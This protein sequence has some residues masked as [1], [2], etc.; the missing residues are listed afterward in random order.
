MPRLPAA[1]EV[2]LLRIAGEALTN[3]VRHA[4]ASHCMV[5]M[6][7]QDAV[8]LQISDDGRGLEPGRSSGVGLASMRRR[9]EELGGSFTAEGR[10][11]RGTLVTVSIPIST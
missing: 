11:P 8:L 1:L 10:L 6:E 7:V 5:Q 3:V 2:A 9:A 4:Q